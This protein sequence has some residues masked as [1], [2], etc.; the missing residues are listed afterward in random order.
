[1]DVLAEVLDAV[2]LRGWLHSRT[3][4]SPPWRFDF[5][6]SRDCVCHVL[7]PAGGYLILD[8]DA[9]PLRLEAGDVVML[10]FGDP[11][12]IC[13]QPTSPLTQSVHLAYDPQRSHSIVPFGDDPDMVML[14][15]AFRIQRTG[16]DPLLRLLPRLVHISPT[17]TDVPDGFTDIV[18]LI[19]LESANPRAG[20]DVILRRLTELLFIQSIRAWIGHQAAPSSGWLGALQDQAIGGALAMIHRAPERPWKVEELADAVRLSRSAFSAR[21]T[22]LV[23]EPPIRYLTRWRMHHATRLLA[24]GVKVHRIAHQ[25]GYDSEAAFRRAFRREIGTPPASYRSGVGVVRADANVAP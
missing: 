25:L 1:M 24:G 5:A 19:A 22:R 4:A 2:E 23:G 14:C 9:T 20:T 10:P 7:G 13:D 15:G 12:Q 18:K 3:E 8:T 6:A 11:H 17:R 16:S 21:F